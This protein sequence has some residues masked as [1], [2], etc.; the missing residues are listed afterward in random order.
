MLCGLG[1]KA[2]IIIL[3]SLVCYLWVLFAAVSSPTGFS[4]K[5]VCRT[6]CALLSF[7]L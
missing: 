2:L 5:F 7:S 3:L 6:P 1:K 4:G